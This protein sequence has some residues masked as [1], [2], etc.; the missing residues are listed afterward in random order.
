ML[1]LCLLFPV[2]LSNFRL[3]VDELP[4]SEYRLV[5]DTENRITEALLLDDTSIYLGYVPADVKGHVCAG[6][7]TLIDHDADHSQ[8]KKVLDLQ[9]SMFLQVDHHILHTRAKRTLPQFRDQP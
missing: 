4:C 6:R 7:P 9:D 1:E 5:Y 2:P 3:R 8:C